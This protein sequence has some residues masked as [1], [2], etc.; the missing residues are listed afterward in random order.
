[1]LHVMNKGWN[2]I[3]CYMEALSAD[4]QMTNKPCLWVMFVYLVLSANLINRVTIK[5]RT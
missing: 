5:G 3:L 1:M 2:G 4:L